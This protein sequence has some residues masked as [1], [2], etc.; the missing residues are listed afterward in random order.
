MLLLLLWVCTLRL[1]SWHAKMELSIVWVSLVLYLPSFETSLPLS[2]CSSMR[3]TM[4][5]H[6]TP[7]HCRKR[8]RSIGGLT[9]PK[10]LRGLSEVVID[11]PG[12]VFWKHSPR[13]GGCVRTKRHKRNSR[14][15]QY[16]GHLTTTCGRV[17]FFFF[18]GKRSRLFD[19]FR[20]VK[21]RSWVRKI[22]FFEMLKCAVAPSLQ[23]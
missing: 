21:W 15:H 16:V 4:P 11:A 5:A 9:T 1:S 20:V 8:H 22:V 13:Q 2:L 3:D 12:R 23:F 19:L 18:H 14:S 17:F 7:L 10:T 6:E